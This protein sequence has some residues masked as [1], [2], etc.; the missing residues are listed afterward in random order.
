M[1]RVAA[2][3]IDPFNQ[4]AHAE[5]WA[6]AV[7][8]FH[9]LTRGEAFV[10][11]RPPGL[12]LE[13]T[14]KALGEATVQYSQYYGTVVPYAQRSTFARGGPIFVAAALIGTAAANASARRA[15]ERMSAPQWRSGGFPRVLLTDQRLLI[16]SPTDFQWHYFRHSTLLEFWPRVEEY[17][18]HLVY[19]D[20][21]PTM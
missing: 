15:A 3:M 6:V 20:C 21:A 1:R 16:R 17:A 10:P 4:Q 2:S 5:G 11:Y 7:R 12:I 9:S 14:E 19:S 18:L 13:P 8:L